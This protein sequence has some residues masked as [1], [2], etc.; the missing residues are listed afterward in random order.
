MIISTIHAK[1]FGAAT[2]VALVLAIAAPAASH[3]ES[4]S[5]GHP[6]H[7]NALPRPPMRS[8]QTGTVVAA[9]TAQ[10]LP[11]RVV[12]SAPSVAIPARGGTAAGRR[13]FSRSR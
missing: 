6:A 8:L 1:G 9:P 10:A 3:A 7:V 13:W 4:R 5:A 11:P 2:A 12:P